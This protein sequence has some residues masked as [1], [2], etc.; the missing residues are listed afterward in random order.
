MGTSLA[1]KDAGDGHDRAEDERQQPHRHEY[2]AEDSE[3]ARTDARPSVRVDL[4]TRLVRLGFGNTK[5][6]LA[7]RRDDADR[8]D[9][10]RRAHRGAERHPRGQADRAQVS[11]DGLGFGLVLITL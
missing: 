1:P 5:L 6:V 3:T 8:H 10:A 9:L 11:G 7:Q 4:A 2:D